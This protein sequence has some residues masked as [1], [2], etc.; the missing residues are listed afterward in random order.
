MSF[1][2][3]PP[4]ERAEKSNPLPF[5]K[6]INCFADY[7]TQCTADMPYICSSGLM[8]GSCSSDPTVWQNSRMCNRFCDTRKPPTYDLYPSYLPVKDKSKYVGGCSNLIPSRD[9]MFLMNDNS[10][11]YVCIKGIANT[12]TSPN[13]QYWQNSQFCKAYCDLRL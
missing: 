8:K 13:P 2:F 4:D 1:L 3:I 5:D 9:L 6:L 12:G 11:P 10:A 7:T